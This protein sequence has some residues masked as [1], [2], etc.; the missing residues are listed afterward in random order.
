MKHRIERRLIKILPALTEGVL[1]QKSVGFIWKEVK[2]LPDEALG[3]ISRR[4]LSAN[5]KPDYNKI[6]FTTFQGDYTCNPKYISE[7]IHELYPDMEIVWGVRK[8]SF[9]HPESFPRYIRLV[10]RATYSFYKEWVTA[11]TLVVNSVDVFKRDMPK[12]KD[13]ILLQT[14]HGSLGIKRFGKDKNWTLLD[15]AIKMAK[16]TDGIISNSSFEDDVYC[17]TFWKKSSIYRLGHARNDLLADTVHNQVISEK[18]KSELAQKYQFNPDDKLFLYAPTFRNNLNVECY[19]LEI[20]EVIKALED[21][22]GGSW[23]ALVRLHPTARKTAKNLAI[24]SDTSRKTIDV[25]LYP[26]IQELMAISDVMIT[27]YSS[28]IYDFILTRRPGFIFATDIEYYNTERGF[29]YPLEATP[30]PIARNNQELVQAIGEFD[31]SA[32]QER[33]ERFLKEKG[34]VDDGQASER[35][36]MLIARLIE[37]RKNG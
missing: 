30:F 12:R 3:S 22:F 10:E 8:D 29:Y 13:Q 28:C 19:S 6:L 23:K 4:I 17:D 24:M 25:T 20:A 5:A 1:L 32:Y 26:D 37:E 21:K 31:E 15:A 11:G 9:L 18:L 27:D 36:A 2:T 33:V 16:V 7:K 14:W 35:A 34:C